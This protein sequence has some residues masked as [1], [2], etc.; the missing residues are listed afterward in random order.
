M[1]SV[2]TFSLTR[3]LIFK[4]KIFFGLVGCFNVGVLVVLYCTLIP[5]FSDLGLLHF[6]FDNQSILAKE[7]QL[8][9]FF[10]LA[11]KY[12]AYDYIFFCVWR[13]N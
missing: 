9:N 13:T 1:K 5:P 10:F 4:Y 12:R 6:F 3:H 2:I 11:L 8:I 7:L